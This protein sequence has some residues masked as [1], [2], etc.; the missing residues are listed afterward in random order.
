MFRFCHRTLRLAA[1]AVAALLGIGVASLSAAESPRNAFENELPGPPPV[2][3]RVGFNL[4]NIT[5]VDEKEETIDF[6]AALYL[7]WQ[8]PRLAF[9]SAPGEG[10]PSGPVTGATRPGSRIYLGDYQVQEVFSGW[11]PHLVIPN[12]IGDR[13]RTNVAIRTWA[14]GR[15]QYTETFY[16]KVE[17]PMDL[18][19]FPFDRQQLEIFFHPFTYQRDQ[20]V[21]L[22]DHELARS[23][24][25]NVG[26]ADWS[27]Q[28]VSVREEPESIAYFDDVKG[29]ISALVVTVEIRRRPLHVVLTI[30]LPM[31]VLV[32]LTWCVFWM[33]AETLSNRVSITFI[34]ILSVVTYYFVVFESLPEI[35]YVTFM[36]G[37]ILATFLILAAGVIVAVLIETTSRQEGRETDPRINKICRWA[38]PLTY[39]AITGI[40]GLVF[41]LLL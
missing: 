21:L 19:R 10:A 1:Q 36:D 25:R 35:N 4:I 3:V 8:D 39:G 30:L 34:G 22:P 27:Q 6:E 9:E 20:L 26:I 14:D 11:R 40:L 5:D 28:G 12:G 2:K 17:T 18:R 15:V 23:W 31:I 13:D 33:D 38:F 7:E 29:T 37:F 24:K 32:A 16:A 41:F